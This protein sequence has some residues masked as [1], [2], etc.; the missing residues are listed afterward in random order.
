MVFCFIGR[1]EESEGHFEGR[2]GVNCLISSIL[3]N[4]V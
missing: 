4:D 1:K 2:K 3:A